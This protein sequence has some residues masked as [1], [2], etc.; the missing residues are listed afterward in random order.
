MPNFKY[1][2]RTKEGKLKQGFLEAKS[3]DELVNILQGR[4]LIVISFEAATRVRLKAKRER[5]F[6]TR[7][8]LDDM[9]IFSRQLTAL[10]KAGITL[11]RS[12]EIT[13]GQVSSR[14]LHIALEEAGKD[15]AAGR[16]LRDALAKHPR[17]FSKFWVSII[18]A[19]E[20]SGQ[21][22]LAIEHLT[23]Y[24]EATAGF[25]RKIISALIYPG[26]ILSVAIVAI[27]VF[28]IRIIPMFA[29][30]YSGFG[31]QLPVFTRVIFSITG[32][33]RRNFLIDLTAIV[34]MIFLFRHYR[35]TPLGRRNI[36]KFLLGAPMVGNVVRQ[37]E[38][39]RFARGLA[40]LIKSG[41]PILHAM[42]IMI[43]SAGNVIIRDVLS[44]V[45]ENVRAGKTMA[46]PMI[47]TGIFPDMLSHMVSVGEESGELANILEK[48][49][50]FYQ[51]RTDAYVTRLT[52]LFEPALIVMIGVI[53]GTLVI[54]MYLPIFGLAGAIK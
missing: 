19:G 43:E 47:E 1:T 45:K 26:V 44:E 4:G 51:E 10:M 9:I 29:S 50:L 53:V 7:V 22:G 2:A 14:R 37:I 35:R 31:A 42:D 24:L 25:R 34:G 40:M 8:K 3:E 48:A 30:I 33:I 5:H 27:L 13:T 41:T 36:D 28:V 46:A 23:Q 38:A 15:V 12:L 20:S 54:A 32:I 49:A 18:E 39:I 16:S 6:H 11:L 17:I 21:L 52:T